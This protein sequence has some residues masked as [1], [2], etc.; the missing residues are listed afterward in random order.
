MA[1]G[2]VVSIAVQPQGKDFNVSLRAQPDSDIL[3]W[4]LAVEA[5][6]RRVLH[7]LD[8]ARG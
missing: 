2:R 8:G 5:G 4:G 1:D 6:K 7:R 3:K